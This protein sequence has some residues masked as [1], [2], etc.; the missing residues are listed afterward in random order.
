[1][2]V[3]LDKTITQVAFVLCVLVVTANGAAANVDVRIL[4]D[5]PGSMKTN[6]VHN[7]R[8]PA[9]RLGAEL[10]PLGA[11]AEIWTF[12]ERVEEL[13][14]SNPVDKQWKADAIRA[15][16]RIH[17]RGQFTDIE[18]ALS[19]A[20][21]GWDPSGGVDLGAVRIRSQI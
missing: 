4:I 16:N 6:D 21:K 11:K 12:S 9:V 19:T 7:L 13:I 15:T 1:M 18:T 8:I 2:L 17:S 14:P 20:T 3:C 10:M 5:V